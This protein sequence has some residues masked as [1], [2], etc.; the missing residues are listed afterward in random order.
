MSPF[1]VPPD[2]IRGLNKP[3]DLLNEY[4]K[5]SHPTWNLVTSVHE[6]IWDLG[7]AIVPGE[8]QSIETMIVRSARRR[9]GNELA[10]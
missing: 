6:R 3:A 4:A 9:H 8:A 5:V 2:S 10:S 7:G 1:K